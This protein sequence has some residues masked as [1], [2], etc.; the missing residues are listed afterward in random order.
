MIMNNLMEKLQN[1]MVPI[2]S[3]LAKIKF[4]SAIA[5]SMQ[6]AMPILIIG[7]FCTLFTNLDIGPWQ[8]IIQSIP[9][10]VST[11]NKISSMTMGAFSLLVLIILT[12]Q[13]SRLIELKEDIVTVP[14]A[15]VVLFIISPVSEAGDI[16]A[17]T[18][19]M[20]A[21]ICTLLVGILVPLACKWMLDHNFVIHMPETVPEFVTKGFA[22]L[23]PGIICCIIAGVIDTLFSMTT[24]GSFQ[25]FIYTSLQMPLSHIG[26]SLWGFLLINTLGSAMLWAGIHANTITGLITPLL[27]AASAENLA[28][29]SAGTVPTNIIDFEFLCMGIP[30]GQAA[31]LLPC[32]MGLVMCKATQLKT[33]SKIGIVPAIFGIGEPI[34]FGFPT[35]FNAMMFIPMVLVTLVNGIFWYAV[36]AVGLVGPFSGVVL[37]WTTPPILNAFLASTTPMQ[38]V[39]ADIVMLA[40]D[41]AIWYP[42]IRIYDKQLA[43]AEAG[44]KA[45]EQEV[46]AEII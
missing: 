18:V 1:I 20:Q 9:G 7:S 37:P 25:G 26:L 11:C 5:S 16:L 3:K 31:L 32:I 2:G 27:L 46:N 35:C 45:E 23:I 17:N 24:F 8:S 19:G 40:L 15:V 38:A 22:I 43:A 36:I 39:I 4:V 29:W 10:F 14:I 44:Q 41:F 12:Y 6:A 28:A 13:Y 33:I 21:L 34:Q 30:G 42:F